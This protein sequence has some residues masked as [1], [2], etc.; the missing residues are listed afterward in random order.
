[1]KEDAL[2]LSAEINE[3]LFTYKRYL[4]IL[5]STEVLSDF[6]PSYYKTRNVS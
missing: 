2:L 5:P 3:D 1:L 6:N 4:K